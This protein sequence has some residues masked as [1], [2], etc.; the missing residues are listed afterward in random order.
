MQTLYNKLTEYKESN[1][2]SFHMPGHKG[3]FFMDDPL[4]NDIA[5]I[6]ITEIEG[7]DDLHHAE[8]IIKAEEE[9]AAA[10]FG[11][12]KSHILVGGSS[13]GILAAIC[14]QTDHGDS[15]LID[16]GC[17]RS[18]Y[19]AVYLNDLRA[20]YLSRIRLPYPFSG[21]IDPAD[22]ERMMDESKAGVV[23][24]TSPTY[25][26]VVSDI[27]KIA[28]IVHDK[29]GILIVDEAHGAHL[30]FM[31]GYSSAKERIDNAKDNTQPGP[32]FPKSAVDL[33]AD[34]VIQSLHKTLPSFTQTAIIHICSDR[35]DL[36]KLEFHLKIH[37]SSSPSYILMAS[38]SR[39]LDILE[40][41]QKSIRSERIQNLPDVGESKTEFQKYCHGLAKGYSDRLSRFYEKTRELEN[42]RIFIPYNIDSSDA[43][44]VPNPADDIFSQ[45][46]LAFDPSKIVILLEGLVRDGKP[47]G[48]RELSD[49]LLLHYDIDL[50]M[51]RPFH[52]LAMTSV[53]DTDEG[54]ERLEKALFEID[55]KLGNTGWEDKN[56][57]DRLKGAAPM[58][59][60]AAV[61]ADSEKL[62]LEDAPGRISAEFVY[63][64]PPGVPLLV[65]G[66]IIDKED[67]DMILES[68]SRGISY[69]R[70]SEGI[71]CCKQ[72]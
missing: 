3:H 35:V 41:A 26:G 1:R 16:R 17:H 11:A 53:M 10:L 31:S 63:A 58:T 52:V 34:I 56:R 49:E 29:N 42:L 64:Y 69:Q 32:M 62:S 39:C 5:R 19:H 66:E 21:G 6:D 72:H 61:N 68:E 12:E 54:F 37:Q 38:V 23:C 43:V 2:Y 18:V 30:H 40:N 60:R 67:I 47:Y 70:D 50:E 20:D 48:G 25:E 55:E 8:G 45:Y 27:K 14:S 36:R 24:I 7:F 71:R 13:S 33:G 15:I 57:E 44:S 51:A 22:V 46:G 28:K 65:P 4:L 9:R 59:I